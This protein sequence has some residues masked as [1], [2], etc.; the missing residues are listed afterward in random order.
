MSMIAI[1]GMFFEVNENGFL[2]DVDQW[3]VSVGEYFA[4]TEGLEMTSSHWEVVHFL[5]EYYRRYQVAPMVKV[6][7]REIGKK[8]GVEKGNTK[9]LIGLFP[10]GPAKQACKIAGLPNT[11]GCV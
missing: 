8:F 2:S 6:I 11:Y 5:Q 1:N 7:T 9:Y 3:S 10:G 4:M